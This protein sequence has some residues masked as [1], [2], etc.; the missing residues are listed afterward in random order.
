M[1]SLI[2]SSQGVAAEFIE[3]FRLLF[4]PLEPTKQFS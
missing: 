4:R 3:F 1:F 2:I